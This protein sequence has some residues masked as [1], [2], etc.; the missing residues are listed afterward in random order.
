M[1]LLEFSYYVSGISRRYLDESKVP[2]SH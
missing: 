2:G 1:Y